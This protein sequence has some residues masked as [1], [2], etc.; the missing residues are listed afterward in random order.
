MRLDDIMVHHGSDKASQASQDW[1]WPQDYCRRTYESVLAPLRELPVT[2]LELG[3]G[4][5]DPVARNHDNPDNGGRSARAWSD[6]FVNGTIVAVE[7]ASKNFP[8]RDAYPRVHL[9]DCTDQTDAAALAAIHRE[10][11]DFDIVVD[12]AS[13]VSSLTIA[14]FKALWPYVTP[15]GWYF[16]EDLHSSY[17]DYYFGLD[18]ANRDPRK[19]AVTAMGFFK[20]LTDDVFY[21]GQRPKGPA[22]DGD[23]CSWD[24][25]PRR[26]WQGYE[27]EEIRFCAPQ[28][29]AIR[30][31]A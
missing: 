11:G 13:H 30:K 14:S 19:D 18:E 3:W 24:C 28:L 26:Y 7:L 29:I 23:P 16:V 21:Q 25:Y 5:Y 31:R 20:R 17:H 2:L 22:V 12:D 4:E 9:Y 27:I 1:Q 6:Y 8:D 10:H 15:G